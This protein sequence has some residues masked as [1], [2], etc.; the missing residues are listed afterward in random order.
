MS[1]GQFFYMSVTDS[2][3]IVMFYVGSNFTQGGLNPL[4][5][6][7]CIHLVSSGPDCHMGRYLISEYIGR[8]SFFLSIC[9][10]GGDAGVPAAVYIA[11]LL[12]LLAVCFVAVTVMIIWWRQKKV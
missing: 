7:C 12:L 4:A 6:M 2:V 9:A 8:H 3:H 10:T 1:T 11:I 5:K